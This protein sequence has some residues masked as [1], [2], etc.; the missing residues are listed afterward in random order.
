MYTDPRIYLGKDPK[1]LK[2]LP[3]FTII[4][5]SPKRDAQREHV[6]IKEIEFLNSD[7]LRLNFIFIEKNNLIF[8]AQAVRSQLKAMM[9]LMLNWKLFWIINDAS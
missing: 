3:W 4:T 9:L 6:L 5:I 7:Y 8:W 1:K 2:S